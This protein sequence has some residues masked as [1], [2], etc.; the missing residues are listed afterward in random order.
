MKRAIVCHYSTL[1]RSHPA[2]IGAALV[3]R[4]GKLL[5]RGHNMR[6]QKGSAIHHVSRPTYLNLPDFGPPP[7]VRGA[8]QLMFGIR[9]GGDV[10]ARELGATACVG[11][12]GRHHVHHA[13]AV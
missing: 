4:D 9:A 10:G 7:L 6:V 1:T 5:G 13:V 8:G 11:L 2:Q 3:S 12:Q